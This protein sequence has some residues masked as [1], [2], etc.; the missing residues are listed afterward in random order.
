MFVLVGGWVYELVSGDT[1]ENEINVWVD[2][3][4]GGWNKGGWLGL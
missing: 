2:M 3:D 4:M 1:I